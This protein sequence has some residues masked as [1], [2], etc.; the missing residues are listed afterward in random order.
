MDGRRPS[1]HFHKNAFPVGVSIW[2][3]A[4]TDRPDGKAARVNV[5]SRDFYHL[6]YIPPTVYRKI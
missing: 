4:S 1:Y 6:K 2:V 5:Q 3:E